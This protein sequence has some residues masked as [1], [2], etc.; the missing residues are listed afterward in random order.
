MFHERSKHIDV[1]L[2]FVRDLIAH[3][4]VCVSKIHTDQ[5]AADFLTKAVGTIKFKICINLLG[6]CSVDQT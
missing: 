5:N 6:L 1:R 4:K 2:Y 3:G